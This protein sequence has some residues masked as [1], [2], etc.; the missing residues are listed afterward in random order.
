MHKILIVE[1]NITIATE[2]AKQ[3]RAWGYDTLMV[4]DF[5]EVVTTFS[6]FQPPWSY[7]IFL[8]PFSMVTIGVMKSV[9]FPRC[10]L[11]L[12]PPWQII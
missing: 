2:I 9:R 12:F 6:D 11:F 10:L 1:D 3:L 7:W 8:C 4:E 5:H